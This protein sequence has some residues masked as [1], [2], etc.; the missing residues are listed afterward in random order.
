MPFSQSLASDLTSAPGKLLV[1]RCDMKKEEDILALFEAAK[2]RFGGV[3]VCVN[4]AG[5]AHNAPLLTGSTS[6]WRDMMEVM[7]GWNYI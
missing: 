4:N 6:D 5:L 2:T 3:D 7:H 1:V